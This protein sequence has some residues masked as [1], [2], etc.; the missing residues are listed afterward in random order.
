MTKENTIQDQVPVLL[1]MQGISKSF[2]GVKALD[3][4]D[5]RI[6]QGEVMGFLGENGAGKSTLMKVLSGVYTRDEGSMVLRGQP[7]DPKSPKDAMDQGVAIIHQEFNLIDNMKVY[8]NIYL[9]REVKTSATLDK[10]TMYKKTG[11]V[12]ER[13]DPGI[14]PGALVE[15]L[16]LAQ[17]QMVEIARALALNADIIIMDE[18]TDALT[19]REVEKL[20][21]VIEDLKAQGKGIVYISHRL[22]EIERICDRF[23][24]L[25]D[26]HYVG[27]RNVKDS[28][29]DEII[30]MMVGRSLED[31]IPYEKIE[32][33]DV[34]L[35]VKN[36][37]NEFVKDISFQLRQG[38]IL[39]IA[40]LVGAG[41]TELG[42]TLYGHYKKDCGD[43]ILNGENINVKN[44]K[45]AIKKGIAYVSEDRK[46]D[47]LVLSMEVNNNMTLSSLKK[48]IKSLMINKKS[49]EV[50]VQ[51]YI[52]NMAIK[53]PSAKQIIENLSGGNQQKVAIAKGLMT[54]PSVLILDEPTRGVDVGAKSEIY[55]ILNDIKKKGK[56]IIII[57]SD[58]PELLGLS[59]RILVVASGRLVGELDRE[60]ASQEKIMELIIKGGKNEK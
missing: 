4:V 29:E 17:K 18:P 54:D 51:K 13:L 15:S 21:K 48:F 55:E 46:V 25:R 58:M 28:S 27:E 52:D 57:S 30:K 23:I 40:G 37:S 53:T 34:S 56:S 11:E 59:D 22:E 24:V 5:F 20:F 19:S 45:E 31:Y 32:L 43:V 60:E 2:P 38:E 42:K 47:G 6:Y 26:G 49:E 35:E 36:L 16:S 33:G 3:K 14:D 1:K 12:L 50:E 39:G 7:Y 8:E 44:E 9:A 10:D 41:R